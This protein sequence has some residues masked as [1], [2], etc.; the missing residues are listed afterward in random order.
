[1]YDD[2]G[3]EDLRSKLMVGCIFKGMSEMK[4]H[5][6]RVFGKLLGIAEGTGLNPDEAL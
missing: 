4:D 5:I 6:A 1:V 3:S 2:L